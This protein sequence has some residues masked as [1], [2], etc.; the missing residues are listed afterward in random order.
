[1]I[2]REKT[3]KEFEIVS[4][5]RPHYSFTVRAETPEKAAKKLIVDLKAV[6]AEISQ[7]HKKGQEHKSTSTI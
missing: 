2:T 3:V 1:M 4:E 5:S 7:H 6:I